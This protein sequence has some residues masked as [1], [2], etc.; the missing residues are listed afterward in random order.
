MQIGEFAGLTGLS[1]DTLRYYEKLGLLRPGRDGSGRRTYTEADYSWVDFLKRLKRIGMPLAQIQ[2]YAELRA[3]GEATLAERM[4]L[5]CS[6]RGELEKQM[7][8][9]TGQLQFLT[10]KIGWYAAALVQRDER[11]AVCVSGLSAD[12]DSTGT[13]SRTNIMSTTMLSGFERFDIKQEP[14]K[15]TLTAEGVTFDKQ[16]AE[17]LGNPQ[18][19]FFLVD[20]DL[21]RVAIQGCDPDDPEGVDFWDPD[22]ASREKIRWHHKVLVEKLQQMGQFDLKNNNYVMAGYLLTQENAMFFDLNTAQAVKLTVS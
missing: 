13:E 2:H 18:R 6:F 8:D 19:V 11:T 10:M 16:V 7:Q 21:K 20:D 17:Q 9:L 3:Q 12:A 15:M 22:D 4:T 5:L 14:P 1:A